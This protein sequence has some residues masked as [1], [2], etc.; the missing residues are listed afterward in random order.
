MS[1]CQLPIYVDVYCHF[2]EVST[3]VKSE[4]MALKKIS[5]NIINIWHS[6]S[7]QHQTIKTTRK[8]LSRHVEVM[9]NL[10]MSKRIYV[11]HWKNQ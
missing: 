8:K 5:E 3:H 2:L 1:K 7:L 9:K 10:K 11:R 4:Y 6:A